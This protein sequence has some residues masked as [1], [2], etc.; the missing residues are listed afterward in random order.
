MEEYEPEDY[1]FPEIDTEPAPP[2][3]RISRLLTGWKRSLPVRSRW[4]QRG[5]SRGLV[6]FALGALP[7]YLLS[8]SVAGQFPAFGSVLQMQLGQLGNFIAVLAGGLLAGGIPVVLLFLSRRYFDI[9]VALLALVV[10]YFVLVPG[11]GLGTSTL[12]GMGGFIAGLTA[13][14]LWLFGWPRVP[15]PTTLGSAQWADYAHIE[16]VGLFAEVGFQL[17]RFPV[18]K[19]VRGKTGPAER[20]IRYAGDRH[21][22]TVAPTRAGKGVS[23]IIPNLLTYPGSAIVIDPKGE[24]ALIT[25]IA[26]HEMG[27]KIALVDPWGIAAPRFKAKPS[28]FNPLDWLR[29]DDADLAE[30]AMLLAD[31][32]VVPSGQDGGSERFWDEEAKAL[33]MGLILHVA[34]AQGEASQRHLGRVR[35]LLT[36]GAQDLRDLFVFMSNSRHPIVRS[37]GERSLQKEEK[38]RANVL[39]AAQSHTHFLESPRI[40]ESLSR[41]DFRFEDLK[42]QATTVY[43]ILPAD[44]LDT[45]GRWLRLLIQQSITVNARNIDRKPRHAVLFMLDEMAALG[46]LKMVE[47]A[48]GLMA[49][50]GVQLWGVVQ[51]LNQLNRI[52]GKGWQT[53]I[54]NSGV[55]QYFGSRDGMTAEYFSKLCGV[56]TVHTIT[57]AIASTVSRA[58]Q[59][60]NPQSS[61]SRT[62]TTTRAENQRNLAY[63]DELMRLGGKRQLLIIENRNPIAADRIIWFEDGALSKLGVNLHDRRSAPPRSPE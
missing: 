18:P 48:Y 46:P 28:C 27:Q 45:F 38:L 57:T 19:R 53:F 10:L 54:A 7:V 34:T 43:L 61:E 25:T 42:S 63:P 15:R 11:A 50:F 62:I 51:D 36:L 33:L 21:L 29:A 30:N 32:L 26:R 20:T 5:L 49:G 60:L 52:Y 23:A 59:G 55:V 37:T 22:L 56:T 35:D 41:S 9:A 4:M 1:L 16:E 31:A 47:Q 6:V 17:A 40:R 24:N 14:W 58:F 2:R 3:N 8:R 13:T 44:R 39:A 12:A